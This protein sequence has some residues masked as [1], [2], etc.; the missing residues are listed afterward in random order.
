MSF[1]PQ[2]RQLSYRYNSTKDSRISMCLS[3]EECAERIREKLIEEMRL[4][5]SVIKYVATQRAV[6]GS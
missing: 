2:R 6:S 5:L 3:L 4:P 1:D